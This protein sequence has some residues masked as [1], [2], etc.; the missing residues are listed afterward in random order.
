MSVCLRFRFLANR[1]QATPWGHHVNEGLVEWPPSPFRLMRALFATGYAKLG[2]EAG[3]PPPLAERLVER[4]CEALPSYHV[5]V[6]AQAHSRHYMPL[7]TLSKDTGMPITTKVFDTFAFVENVADEDHKAL[8]VVWQVSLQPEERALL[9]ELASRMSYLGRAESWVEASVHAGLPEPLALNAVPVA[10]GAR[11]ESGEVIEVLAPLPSA[12][13]LAWRNGAFEGAI[14][15]L[16][17]EGKKPSA[18]QRKELAERFPATLSQALCNTTSTLQKQAWTRPPGTQNVT[19]FYD[20]PRA[21]PQRAHAVVQRDAQ[22]RP[23]CVLFSLT[24]DT[25]HG[26]ARPPIT[27]ALRIG[28]LFHTAALSSDKEN[29]LPVSELLTGKSGEGPR[30]DHDHVHYMGL[31]L[32]SPKQI[33]HLLA[34]CPTGF[35]A[36]SIRRLDNLRRIWESKE[37]PTL[38]VSIVAKGD[39]AFL[40][41]AGL[42]LPL[43]G[44]SRTFHSA[45]PF[46]CPRH[47]KK[48]GKNSVEGQVRAELEQRNLSPKSIEIWSRDRT[49]RLRFY[50]FDRTR[51]RRPPPVAHPFGLTITFAE[52]VQGPLAI[53]YGSHFGLGVL[54]P[55]IEAR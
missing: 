11:S 10:Q 45:T 3:P 23:T 35:D 24:S 38:F 43:L 6:S 37:D 18:K 20:A 21:E 12:Q 25:I 44:S 39:V 8:W 54:V 16:E 50:A 7:G 42:R 34:W 15:A 40:K 36:A 14:L 1:Y 9:E 26:T 5:P 30:G 33:D 49:D 22:V 19:Y 4:L 17:A 13:Y 53:G 31:A 47:A 52:D 48:S 55:A 29:P 51:R 32:E 46:I 2:W 41:Q 28:E 27:R